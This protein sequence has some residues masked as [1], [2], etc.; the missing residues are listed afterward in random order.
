[1]PAFAFLL[2]SFCISIR[3]KFLTAM[4]A[5]AMLALL[6]SANLALVRAAEENFDVVVF[7]ATSGGVTAEARTLPMKAY[8]NCSR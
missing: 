2:R 4:L 7:G 8:G 6:A 5:G 3:A 1:M